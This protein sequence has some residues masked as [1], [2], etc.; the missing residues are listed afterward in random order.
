MP[1]VVVYT[2]AQTI[3]IN[4]I[5]RQKEVT[6]PAQSVMRMFNCNGAS[7]RGEHTS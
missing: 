4:V 5:D 3:I 1:G 7:D 6:Q 2:T